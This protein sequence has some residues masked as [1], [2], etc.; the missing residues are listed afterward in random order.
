MTDQPHPPRVRVTDPGELTQVIPYLIGFTPEESLAIVVVERGQVAVTARVDIADIQPAGQAEE[1]LDRMWARFPQ[2]SALLIAYTNDRAA[3]W[4]LL[5][6]CANRLPGGRTLQAMVVDGDT[7]H[8]P[9]GQT[10]PADRFGP[11]AAEASFHGLQRLPSRTD[12]AAGFA[13]PPVTDELITHLDAAMASLPDPTDTTA[14]I[15]RMGDLVRRN[16]PD[17]DTD[18]PFPAPI[19]T[20]EALQLAVLA[21][22]PKAREVAMLSMTRTDAREHLT[23]WRTVVHTVPEFGAE[24]PLF[25]AGMAA[26]VAG[27]GAAASIALQR[28]DQAG[29]PGHYPPARLLDA[30]IDQVVPP[31]AWE[32]LRADGLTSADPRVREAVTGSHTPKTWET[33][34]QQPLRQHPQPPEVAPPAPGIAI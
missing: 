30:L 6:R 25:L 17:P 12:L 8:L 5:E 32:P 11:L 15:T 26:W 28:T 14:L 31:S 3:G 18:H 33:I 21:Q 16:L 1:L 34:P 20:E 23:M 10:G 2:G 27:E 29:E 22:H 9:D 4:N 24:A 7:W 19:D 13:S